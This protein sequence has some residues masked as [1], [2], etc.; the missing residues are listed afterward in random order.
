MRVA[1]LHNV[2]AGSEDHADAQLGALIL[3]AG[4]EVVH[5]VRRVSEL[6]AALHASP[7]DLVVVAGGDGTVGKVAC[8]LAGW[9]VPLSI[10]AL[11]TANNTARS[12]KMPSRVSKVVKGWTTASSVAFDLGLVSDGVLRQ[13]FAEALGWGVFAGAIAQ[14]HLRPRRRSVNRALK[15]DRK[16]FGIAARQ[17]TARFYGVEVD[18][19]D[20]SGEYLLVEV[21]NVP[22]LGPRLALSP[23][24]DPGDGAFEVVLVG[25]A[26]RSALSDLSNTGTMPLHGARVE[27][28]SHIRV[29]TD[30]GLLHRDGKL[31][32]HAPGERSF[33]IC[34]APAA[35]S[36]L[37]P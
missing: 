11:G 25:E 17:A 18:G 6:T 23:S 28:G 36:Y 22:L 21:M 8:E 29:T 9:R 15:Q 4:H 10:L 3:R 32:R 12:L 20:L 13:R 7:C 27:R 37:R 2:S 19:R 1:L 30:Q 5:V 14:A 24:S 16:R 35:I 31:V 33:E 26:G 34:V